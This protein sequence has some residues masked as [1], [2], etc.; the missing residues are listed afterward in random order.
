MPRARPG[1]S[2]L[3]SPGSAVAIKLPLR[4]VTRRLSAVI[5]FPAPV[6]GSVHARFALHGCNRRCQDWIKEGNDRPAGNEA[7]MP[8]A[9]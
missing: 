2:H 7:E 5:G 6:P 4:A 3:L 8:V 9:G 1:E